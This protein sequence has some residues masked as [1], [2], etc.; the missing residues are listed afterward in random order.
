M[1]LE[2]SGKF[3]HLPIEGLDYNEA[4]TLN[5]SQQEHNMKSKNGG[6]G[7]TDEQVRHFINR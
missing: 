6:N 4:L 7:M 5:V 2:T 3:V 1:D